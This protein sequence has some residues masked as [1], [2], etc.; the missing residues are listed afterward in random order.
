M[1]N[2][3]RLLSLLGCAVVLWA[4]PLRSGSNELNLPPDLARY[5][6]WPQLMKSPYQ[7]PLELWLL[8]RVPTPAD[9]VAAQ[10]K[11][12]P[13]TKR[14]IRV[15]GNQVVAQA[16]TTGRETLP[17]RS[18]AIIAKEKFTDARPDQTVGVGFMVK[19]E[20]SLFP[21]TDGWQFL[22]YP[23]ARDMKRTHEACAA[24]HRAASST[25][26]VFGTYPR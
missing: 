9:W 14:Y 16:T 11:Y 19:R 23:S 3:T 12:C 5:R 26:Y 20:R 4:A 2:I 21:E 10:E 18:G 25:D 22:Y 15:Y 24:C 17:F 7:V 13:H 8:C 6:E 1:R